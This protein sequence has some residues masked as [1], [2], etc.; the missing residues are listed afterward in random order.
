M[1]SGSLI[2]DSETSTLPILGKNGPFHYII[3]NDGS[4]HIVQTVR[5]IVFVLVIWPFIN[6][7]LVDQHLIM[8]QFLGFLINI[9]EVEYHMYEMAV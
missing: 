1:R 3:R 8:V 2:P 4:V 6:T 5:R 7:S 9:Y